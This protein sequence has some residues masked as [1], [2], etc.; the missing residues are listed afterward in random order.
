MAVSRTP[1]VLALRA[2]GLGDTLAGVPALRALRRAVAAA[3]LTVA[4]PAALSPLLELAGIEADIYDFHGLEGELPPVDLGV[5]LHGRGP[6]SHLLLLEHS[7]RVV[8]FDN[9]AAGVAGPLWRADEHERDRW[10]R[11]VHECFGVF[12]DPL[13]YALA[14]PVSPVP[15]ALVVHPG[16]ASRA[17][18]WPAERFAEIVRWGARRGFDVAITGSADERQ[19][20]A[21]VAALSGTRPRV[22]AGELDLVELAGLIAHA[23]CVVVGDTGVGHLVASYGVPSIHLF[24]PVSPAEWG[25][26]RGPH[27]VLWH[28]RT[29]DP[30]GAL[31]DRGLLDIGVREVLAT[32]D[33]MI[34]G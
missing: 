34:P 6:E 15:G 4:M 8:G 21:R 33:D 14:A 17:R 32:L 2:L 13:D 30:H 24:G 11:L 10:C 28:G 19:L 16:A 7:R 20:A 3:R 22:L 1:H 25:P 9:E 27:V 26:P 12:A 18:R 23:C 29:G 5:N 31:P